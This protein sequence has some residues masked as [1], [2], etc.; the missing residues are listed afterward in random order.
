MHVKS[1][2]DQCVH[3]YG[4]QTDAAPTERPSNRRMRRK[5]ARMHGK[6]V[7][8]LAKV[9]LLPAAEQAGSGVPAEDASRDSMPVRLETHIW[10]ARR[11]KMAPRCAAVCPGFVLVPGAWC[12]VPGAS[13]VYML[14]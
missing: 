12:L 4:T 1:R 5:L 2:A 13:A 3:C 7:Q 11:M 14:Q 9:S 10:H 8:Q 6:I